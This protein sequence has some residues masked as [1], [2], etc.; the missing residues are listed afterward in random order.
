[1]YLCRDCSHRHRMDYGSNI[2]PFLANDS[3]FQI[4]G[5]GIGSSAQVYILNSSLP[6]LDNLIYI[7]PL[8]TTTFLNV[9]CSCV[10]TVEYTLAVKTVDYATPLSQVIRLV[11][12][13]DSMILPHRRSVYR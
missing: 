10:S 6:P 4:H 12:R 3:A 8:S 9:V 13:L 11:E 2:S 1:M 7:V 5:I